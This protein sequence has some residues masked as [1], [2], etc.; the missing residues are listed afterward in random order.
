LIEVIADRN[1]LKS[2]KYTVSTSIPVISEEDS[3]A[4]NPD[5]YF[6]L[7]WHFLPEFIAREHEFLERGGKF[8]VSMPEFRVI[9]NGKN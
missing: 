2:G 6:V 8:I 5:Y 9:G 4:K 1:P 7:A 3:R